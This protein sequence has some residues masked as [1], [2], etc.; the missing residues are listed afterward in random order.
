MYAPDIDRKKHAL[1]A[2]CYFAESQKKDLIVLCATGSASAE[3]AISAWKRKANLRATPYVI[4]RDGTVFETFDPR[5]WAFHL[6]MP[7]QMNP[8]ARNDRRSIAV[9]LVNPGALR[10]RADGRLAWWLDNFT[11]PWCM[12]EDTSRSMKANFRGFDY[13]ATYTDA[14][15]E[16]LRALLPWLCREHGIPWQLPAVSER[17]SA[18]PRRFARFRGILAHHHFRPEHADVG[19]AFDWDRI[20]PPSND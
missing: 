12:P 9:S 10:P 18:D 14:Q 20:V 13:F 11:M 7:A 8:T 17:L 19:P 4:E 3:P 6:N 2:A 1:P 15:F 5:G 16:A